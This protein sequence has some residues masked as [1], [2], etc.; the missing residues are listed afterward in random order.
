MK[1]ILAA[2]LAAMFL[3]AGSA[4]AAEQAA[5]VPEAGAAVSGAAADSGS[6]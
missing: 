4:E 3:F 6:L 2:G 5:A 1:K